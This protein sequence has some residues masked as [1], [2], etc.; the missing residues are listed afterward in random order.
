MKFDDRTVAVKELI[1]LLLQ[2]THA[3]DPPIETHA[4]EERRKENPVD[5]WNAERKKRAKSF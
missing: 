2:K 4:V 1:R 3:E 5:E